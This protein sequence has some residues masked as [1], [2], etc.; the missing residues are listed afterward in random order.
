[1]IEDL[2]LCGFPGIFTFILI[3][4]KTDYNKMFTS[5]FK[6]EMTDTNNSIT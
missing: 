4:S 1:M 5:I 3:Y 2:V 6:N